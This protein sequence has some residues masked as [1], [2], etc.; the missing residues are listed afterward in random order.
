MELNA[1]LRIAFFRMRKMLWEEASYLCF[2]RYRHSKISGYISKLVKSLLESLSILM[3]KNGEVIYHFTRSDPVDVPAAEKRVGMPEQYILWNVSAG[4]IFS[5]RFVLRIGKKAPCFA[6]TMWILQAKY[7]TFQNIM[8]RFYARWKESFWK[9]HASFES[10][11]KAFRKRK[12]F[13]LGNW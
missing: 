3:Y 9:H 7:A 13:W 4:R 10:G 2:P 12:T 5:F 1:R 6:S 11:Y 8:S